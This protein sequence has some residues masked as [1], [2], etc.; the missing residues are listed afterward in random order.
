[1]DEKELFENLKD[2]TPKKY[3]INEIVRFSWPVR[4]LR[5]KC[6]VNKNPEKSLQQIYTVMLKAIKMGYNTEKSL[7]EFLGLGV[8]DEFMIHELF[9]LQ[10]KGFLFVNDDKWIVTTDGEDFV[11]G[12]NAKLRIEEFE[13]YELIMD[14]I[15]GSF[16]SITDSNDDF[17]KKALNKKLDVCEEYDFGV[18]SEEMFNYLTKVKYHDIESLYKSDS[19]GDSYL[20][21]IDS[22]T[23]DEKKWCNYWFVEY[24]PKDNNCEPFVEIRNNE[25]KLMHELTK[26]AKSE[27]R[28]YIYSLTESDRKD[29]E[30]YQEQYK[31]F[32][33]QLESPQSLQ[34]KTKSLTV[35]ETKSQFIDALQSVK[36]K[37]LIE[38]PWIKKATREYIPYF[39]KLLEAGKKL[40]VLYGISEDDEHDY[41]TVEDIKC[42]QEKEASKG[43]L[44]DLPTYL[45]NNSSRFEG[46]HRKILVKD[47][48]Y[49]ISG[50][51]NFLSFNKKEGEKIANEESIMV[52]EGVKEKWEKIEKEYGLKF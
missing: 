4:E 37:I 35:W 31:K 26:K 46:S 52:C 44:I 7:F 29:A 25:C 6:L 15:S 47:N 28:S 41:R 34:Y 38:S 1:M 32:P 36:E 9:V 5:L 50:S 45:K 3:V 49:Y 2:K 18:K 39:E 14:S 12:N 8:N 40:Y 21:D 10:E 27:Y 51:F 17:T 16:I 24:K 42:L 33:I 22:V 43:Q 11:N 19:R 23:Y 30:E 13:E 48:D 20:I